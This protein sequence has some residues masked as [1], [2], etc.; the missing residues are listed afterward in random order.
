[1]SEALY[2]MVILGDG[3]VGKS[4]LTIQLIQNHFI[5]DYDPTI[6][7]SYRKQVMVDNIS[8]VLEIMDT[9]GQEELATMRNQY[10]QTGDGFIIVYSVIS[11]RTFEAV[12]KYRSQIQKIKDTDKFPTVIVGNKMDLV[13]QREVTTLQGQNLSEQFGIPFYECSAKNRLN[14]E[15][16]FYQCVREIRKNVGGEGKKLDDK[17][18]GGGRKRRRGCIIL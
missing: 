3:G 6:E 5:T 14:V 16:S 15:E 2:R 12:M 4:A 17:K 7:N 8:T 18:P 9:A 13:E 10:I 1:M 11:Y